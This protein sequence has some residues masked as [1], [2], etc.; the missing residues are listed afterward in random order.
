MEVRIDK[1]ADAAV[2]TWA[3]RKRGGS[4]VIELPGGKTV[5]FLLGSD[6][7][8]AGLEVLGWS[9]RAA[10]PY[11]VEVS[12]E[13]APAQEIGPDE[14]LE[15]AFASRGIQTRHDGRP[16]D[17]GEPMLPMIEVAARTGLNRSWLS[18]E[19]TSGRL[20]AKKIGREWWTTEAWL[21][22]YQESRTI[23]RAG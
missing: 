14:S 7:D 9:R 4:Q 15:R 3:E 2:L 12:I 18:R 11:Q 5:R 13:D 20:R 10:R 6:G 22:A 17:A 19:A 21:E 23:R 8:L 16:V 1:A